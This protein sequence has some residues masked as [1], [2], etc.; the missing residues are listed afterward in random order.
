[1]LFKTSLGS[2]NGGESEGN[3]ITAK[4]V[5]LPDGRSLPY[6]SG[7]C[8]RRMLKERLAEMGEVLSPINAPEEQ[9]KESRKRAK[10]PDF[11]SGDPATYIDDDL[12]GYL[13]AE[14]KEVR[15]RTAPVRASAAV[16]LFPYAGDRDYGT[17]SKES[18]REEVT[19]EGGSKLTGN[20]FETEIYYNIFRATVLVE[21]DRVGVFQ[22]WELGKLQNL[23]GTRNETERRRR[24]R[25]LVEAILNLWGGGKQ[26]R[27]L[28]DLGPKLLVYTRQSRKNPILLEALMMD[29]RQQLQ[30][31]PL[32]EAL[33]DYRQYLDKVIVGVRTGFLNDE[34]KN[35]LREELTK[36]NGLTN[37]L[38]FSSIG[39]AGATIL[40]DIE[41]MELPSP[42]EA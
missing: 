4:K 22:P 12:L 10:S 29:E 8:I 5:T 7:Q 6:L 37:K 16:G 42:R 15:R 36:I 23:E 18:S 31:Q 41:K 24:V 40:S 33:G 35:Q 25:V 20:I 28:T 14:K 11:T 17:R 9:E 30:I 27:L 39:E 34:Q 3:I 32:V 2:I 19:E 38:T 26:S 21:L 1:M 13:Q